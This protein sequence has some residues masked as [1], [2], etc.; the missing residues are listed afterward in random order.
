MARSLRGMI[1]RSDYPAITRLRINEIATPSLAST[2]EWACFEMMPELQSFRCH[3]TNFPDE[4]LE[5][6]LYS[7]DAD[8]DVGATATTAL[9]TPPSKVLC[10]R[11]IKLVFE[12]CNL[13]GRALVALSEARTKKT[14]DVEALQELW[15]WQCP[16][17]RVRDEKKL[18][19]VLGDRY[20]PTLQ[21]ED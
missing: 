15:T 6:F 17:V 12:N 10:P 11:L 8:P 21:K 19:A 14:G 7:A 13:S 18:Q 1:E 3:H 2:G 5:R 16:D 9:V 20:H 4:L